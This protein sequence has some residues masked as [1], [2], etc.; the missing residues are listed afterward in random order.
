M[1]FSTYKVE[2]KL[3]NDS[4]KHGTEF[5]KMM[6]EFNEKYGLNIKIRRD[7]DDIKLL[8]GKSKLL[9]TILNIF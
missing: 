8:P 3:F 6:N 4:L 7:W 9:F 5:I 1:F 2:K